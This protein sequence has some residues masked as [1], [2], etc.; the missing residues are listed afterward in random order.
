RYTCFLLRENKSY[1]EKLL[2]FDVENTP[3]ALYHI[4]TENTTQKNEERIEFS[5]KSQNPV[6]KK[7]VLW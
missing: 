7:E 6:D 4:A 3:K 2:S 1:D 5:V